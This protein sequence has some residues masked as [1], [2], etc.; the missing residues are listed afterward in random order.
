MANNNISFFVVH[1]DDVPRAQRFYG[2]AFGWRFEAWGPPGFFLIHTGSKENPGIMGA[3]Q[4]RQEPVTGAGIIGYECTITV[5]DVHA[6]QRAVEQSGG[7]IVMPPATIPTVGTMIKFHDTE[8]N[9]A[10]AMQYEAGAM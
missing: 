6:T 1:A 8:G 4:K 3:L 9:L 5:E 10:G 2:N 7:T